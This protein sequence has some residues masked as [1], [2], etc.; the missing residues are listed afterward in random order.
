VPLLAGL[1]AVVA[2]GALAVTLE[3][4]SAVE[5]Q[6]RTLLMVRHVCERTAA[7]LA[8]RLRELFGAALVHS[9]ES[10][11]HQ[12][13]KAYNL[14]RV[15]R[16]LD[17]GL[18]DYPYVTRFFLWH[19]RFPAPLAGEVLFYRPRGHPGPRAIPIVDDGHPLGGFDSDPA[20]GR[21]IW[22]VC[23]DA[24]RRGKSFAVEEHVV[25]GVRYQV[26][27]HLLWD[28]A[29]RD[30]IFGAIGFLVALDALKQTQFARLVEGL[31]PVLDADADVVPLTLH[32][33]DERGRTVYGAASPVTDPA[34]SD[35]LDL[36]FFPSDLLGVYAA[37]VPAVPRWRLT[38]APTGPVSGGGKSSLALLAAVV[39]LLLVAVACATSVNRQAIR[40]SQL[41]SDF[42]ANVTHQLRTPLALLSGAAETLRLERVRSPGKVKEYADIVQAQTRRLS[43]LVD[44]ILHFH[45]AELAGPARVWQPVDLG[46]LTARTA[47]QHRAAASSAAVT[48]SVESPAPGPVVRGDPV[49]LECVISNLLENA[50]KYRRG[51][52]D[53]VTVSVT[54]D[55]KY[56]VLSVRD[57]GVGISCG[58]LPN[59]FDKFY[60]GRAEGPSRPGFGLGL[61]I[62]RSTVVG[63]GGRIA[64]ES[65]AGQ[66]SAFT[67]WLPLAG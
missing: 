48:I 4:Q 6:Q 3:R 52:A 21:P 17:A 54:S 51:E 38:V 50:V 34:G 55:R 67:V 47:E 40:L 59:I 27:L 30:R 31:R 25:D 37:S 8:V 7:T 43:V 12:E 39:L 62:V 2:A 9:I 24:M 57:R 16:F 35:S 18:R 49:A 42:V 65:E 22:R 45:R 19:E 60:R 56:G 13:L 20:S 46:A 36:L 63:H 61:A 15:D 33:T 64:V 1:G 23:R 5:Q 53:H 41:Q 58:D 32:V 10:I 14:V 29:R 44:E 26:V 28:G 11:H 66:G